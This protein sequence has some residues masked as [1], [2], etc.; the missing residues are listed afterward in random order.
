MNYEDYQRFTQEDRVRLQMI[1]LLAEL[2]SLAKQIPN[3]EVLCNELKQLQ[4]KIAYG[5]L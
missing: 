5:G 2:R 3:A 4:Y 1:E